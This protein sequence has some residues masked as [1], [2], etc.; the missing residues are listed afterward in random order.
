MMIFEMWFLFMAI[1]PIVIFFFSTRGDSFSCEIRHRSH[2]LKS[3]INR[4]R[5][6]V[7]IL[8]CF[9]SFRARLKYYETRIL[10][11]LSFVN[12]FFSFRARPNH[13]F[14]HN[15]RFSASKRCSSLST[16]SSLLEIRRES[17]VTP[18]ICFLSLLSWIY[19]TLI[20]FSCDY[21]CMSELKFKFTKTTVII[22]FK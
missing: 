8:E 12:N 6:G 10:A 5:A 11:I 7:D 18:G 1:V 13:K 4:R 3:L 2:L 17:I 14:H 9:K 20:Y 19:Y 15:D 21:R 22:L 16:E